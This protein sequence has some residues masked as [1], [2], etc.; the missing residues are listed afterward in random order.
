MILFLKHL[1]VFQKYQL[2]VRDRGDMM[3]NKILVKFTVVAMMLGLFSPSINIKKQDNQQQVE[4]SILSKAEARRGGGRSANRSSNRNVNRNSNRNVNRN[5]NRNRNRNVNKN[6]NVNVNHGN[7]RY[8][9]GHHHGGYGH[10]HGRPILAFTSAVAIGSIIAASTMPT[11][12]T[13]VVANGVSYRKC[14]NAYYQP[15]YQGDTLVYKAVAS[16]Y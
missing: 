13:T 10:Y 1:K 9:G 5:S 2:K 11:T 12:C 4:I 8:Y 7:S 16:P 3:K 15:F 14:S 6:V